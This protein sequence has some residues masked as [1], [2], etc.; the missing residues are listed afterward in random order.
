MNLKKIIDDYG[1]EFCMIQYN[2]IDEHYQAGTEGLNYAASKKHWS[3]CNGT[4]KRRN[5]S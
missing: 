4:S 3:N 5:V 1:W 2:Y